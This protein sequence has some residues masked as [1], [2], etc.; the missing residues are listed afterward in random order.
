MSAEN[1]A[2][3]VSTETPRIEKESDKNEVGIQSFA[4]PTPQNAPGAKAAKGHVLENSIPLSIF[5][6]APDKF[7]FCFCGLPGRGKTHISR[8]LGRYLEFFHA[9]PVRVFNV[10]DYRRQLCGG[11]K[12]ADW[13]DSNNA[14]AMALRNQ[15]NQTCIKDMATFL[16]FC[17]NGVAILDSTNPTHHRRQFLLSQM[18]AIGAKV[19]FIEVSNED[20]TFLARQYQTT[21]RY[22]VDYAGLSNTSSELD[23]R[24]KVDNYK[25]YFEPLDS[26]ANKAIEGRWSYMKADH[27]TQHF[28]VHNVKGYLQQ[29][30][31]NFIMNLRTTSHAF[32]LTRHGQSEYN[33]LGRIGGDSG[34]TE[35]GLRYARQLAI[36]V[37]EQIVRDKETGLEVPARLWTSTMRRTKETAQF[38]KQTKIL[39]RS[40]TQ[41]S[42]ANADCIPVNANSTDGSGSGSIISNE[43]EIV[44]YEWVQMRPRAWHH[45]DELFAGSCDGMTYEEIEERFPEEWERRN[46]DKLAYRYPR[47]ESYL[48]VIARLEPIIIEMERHQEPLLIVA[49]QAILRIIY[50]FYTGHSRGEAPYLSIPLNTVI[51]LV[52]GPVECKEQRHVLYKPVTLPSDG[53]DEPLLLHDPPS[54]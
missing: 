13:F 12:D 27:S 2:L 51:E 33:D 42:Y 53:Q 9:V 7:V 5:P 23:Y 25:S 22:S 43:K 47:G 3:K 6:I 46:V 41:P 36:F 18:H 52:P 39:L 38:I 50:A 44:E 40:Q 32:Y 17:D 54:H 49:H 15:C 45:L 30:V 11:L 4:H 34:L 29:K 1:L 37:E 24:K 10:A 26:G 14:E 35:H 8:R 19:M 31:V 20:E 16:A 28:V 21:V 48:D